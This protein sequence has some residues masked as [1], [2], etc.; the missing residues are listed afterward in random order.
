MK[1]AELVKQ[2]NKKYNC[3]YMVS[4]SGRIYKSFMGKKTYI[5]VKKMIEECEERERSRNAVI[6]SNIT[7]KYIED[8][9]GEKICFSNTGSMYFFIGGLKVRISDHFM[10]SY[11]HHRPD[12]NLCS[13][14]KDGWI[15]MTEKINILINQ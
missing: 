7:R 6:N 2:T 8:M 9:G 15:D 12:V 11:K 10:I 13:Y 14:E 5:S 4:E 3:D 1:T